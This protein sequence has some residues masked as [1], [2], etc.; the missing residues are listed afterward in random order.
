M[1]NNYNNN[2]FNSQG[3]MIPAT[4]A[5][6]AAIEKLGYT[7]DTEG[8]T[9]TEASKII[10]DLQ[11]QRNSSS[12]SY[13][14]PNNY[15][16]SQSNSYSGQNQVSVSKNDVAAVTNLGMA[17][18]LMSNLNQLATDGCL[19]IPEN[20]SVGNA[21]KSAMSKILT[22]DQA[23]KLLAC[24]AESKKQ[25]LTEYIVQ[26]LDASKTQAYFIPYGNKMTMMRSYFGDVAVAKRTGLIQDIYAIVIYA[27]D[28]VEIG[29]D[30]Y[31][32]KT[33]ISH[34]TSFE[35][36]DNEIVGAY[37]VAVGI[38]GYKAYEFMT[39]KELEASWKMS[40]M[41]SGKLHTDYKQEAAKR[42]V[43]RR[44][45]KMIFNTSLNTTEEQTSVIDSY[46]RT[47]A[48]EYIDSEETKHKNTDNVHEEQK[49]KTASKKVTPANDNE[50]WLNN[51]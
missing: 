38:N 7:G 1:Q 5:Q 26:G 23:D 19:Y 2:L 15:Q 20:Y 3:E 51:D 17:D 25:A 34:K 11:K 9:K 22:S 35:N 21:L 40:K 42:T 44:A 10:Q 29:F 14:A 49:N 31:G 39:R 33:L 45:V 16:Q 12:T 30:D 27:G 28:E 6:I 4:D 37:A 13:Q 43:I 48:D 24:T 47:T 8:L 18:E 50:D 32:R 46:N 36:Q 41:Q